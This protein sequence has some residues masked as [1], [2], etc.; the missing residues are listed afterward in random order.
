MASPAMIARS[1]RCSQACWTSHL[2]HHQ[3]QRWV[4]IVGRSQVHLGFPLARPFHSYSFLLVEDNSSKNASRFYNH[5]AL[6]R[7]RIKGELK[8]LLSLA[9]QEFLKEKQQRSMAKDYFNDSVML[10]ARWNGYGPIDPSRIVVESHFQAGKLPLGQGLVA[11]PTPSAS[12]NYK[13]FARRCPDLSATNQEDQQHPT[14]VEEDASWYRHLEARVNENLDRWEEQAYK[15]RQLRLKSAKQASQRLLDSIQAPVAKTFI[16]VTTRVG[17]VVES[18]RSTVKIGV[19]SLKDQKK[20]PT[21]KDPLSGKTDSSK[22]STATDTGAEAPKA[23]DN[24]SVARNEWNE[25]DPEDLIIL[26]KDGSML[27]LMEKV[28]PSVRLLALPIIHDVSVSADG[29]STSRGKPKPPFRL[30][31]ARGGLVI[32][33]SFI[34]LGALAPAYRSLKFILTYPNTAE[35]VMITLVGSMAYSMWS[36]ISHSKTRQRELVATAIQSRLVARGHAAVAVLTNGAVERLAEVIMEEYATRL[37]SADE[38]MKDAP[39]PFVMEI[40]R[41]VG[42]FRV[43]PDHP[44]NGSRDSN[45]KQPIVAVE[46]EEA[47]EELLHVLARRR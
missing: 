46:W 31:L 11:E 37:L 8:P 39:D 43:S 17:P 21:E 38:T 4:P 24:S 16:V 1:A 25:T 6:Q 42:L 10:L 36:W 47:R 45:H 27:L 2:R 19:K 5:K 15:R 14:F 23:Y 32:T 41:A 13:I 20:K 33:A 26:T 7:A 44:A 22:K 9:I 34:A 29:N 40:G 18:V 35:I 28:H 3:Q 12:D 30:R